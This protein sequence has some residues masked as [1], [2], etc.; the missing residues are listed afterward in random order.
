[1]IAR[2]YICHP[3]H[4]HS[5]LGRTDNS[6]VNTPMVQC[7]PSSSTMQ[8]NSNPSFLAPISRGHDITTMTRGISDSWLPSHGSN[9]VNSIGSSNVWVTDK[10][11]L[12]QVQHIMM[13]S[14]FY[15]MVYGDSSA[16]RD[17]TGGNGNDMEVEAAAM[18]AEEP[19]ETEESATLVDVAM[20]TGN[21][22]SG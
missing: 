15:T 1:M 6:M 21:G 4:N 14:E 18:E 9:Q 16:G 19:M 8:L 7:Y 3:Y 22:I 20:G 11:F 12:E 17:E 5:T 13:E 2:H 10:P